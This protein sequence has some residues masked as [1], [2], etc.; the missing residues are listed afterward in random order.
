M[1]PIRADHD[2]GTFLERDTGPVAGPDAANDSVLHEETG[3]LVPVWWAPCD[4]DLA[5]DSFLTDS[6][7][8]HLAL[9]QSVAVDPAELERALETLLG[10]EDLRKRMGERSRERAVAE[11]AWPVVIASAQG[12]ACFGAAYE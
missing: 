3:F 5:R 11:F 7:T 2:A 9:A 4:R 1:H 8:D 6:P 12:A 10:N